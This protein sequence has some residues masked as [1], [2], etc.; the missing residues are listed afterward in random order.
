GRVGPPGSQLGFHEDE[1]R[2]RKLLRERRKWVRPRHSPSDRQRC[3]ESASC[4]QK[5][6]SVCDS[7]PLRP[8]AIALQRMEGSQSLALFS[9]GSARAWYD[10]ALNPLVANL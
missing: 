7:L 6:P 10:R 4:T 9:V 2:L 5:M 1:H 3:R 8:V